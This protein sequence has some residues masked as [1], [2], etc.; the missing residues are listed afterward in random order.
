MPAYVNSMNAKVVFAIYTNRRIIMWT[1]LIAIF[2]PLNKN[3]PSLAVLQ[4]WG[5]KSLECTYISKLFSNRFGE[6]VD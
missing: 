3:N 2:R 1:L 5:T 6:K 4:S